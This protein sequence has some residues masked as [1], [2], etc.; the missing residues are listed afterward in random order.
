MNQYQ[1]NNQDLAPL[2]ATQTEVEM[3]DIDM[4]LMERFK[5]NND[6]LRYLRYK[7]VKEGLLERTG[8]KKYSI[9]KNR[10][11][12]IPDLTPKEKKIFKTL[13]ANKPYL[14][15]CVWRTSILNE[16]TRHQVGRFMIMVE[17]ER[18]GVEAVFDLLRDKYPNV[19]LNPTDKEIDFYISALY[20][21]IVVI[22]LVSE[23]P[24]Q[25]IDGI[26]T[27][28][29]EKLLVDILTEDKLYQ[30]FQSER[31][32]IIFEVNSKYILN[33]NKLLRYANRRR[34]KDVI[35]NL[36]NNALI[37]NEAEK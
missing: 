5:I 28:T 21:A 15:I 17:V 3:A 4:F 14:N 23:A 25:V 7:L 24:T 35:A 34:R 19:F 22:P 20:E 8:Y 1:L 13:R 10:T 32:R 37:R 27:V 18:V 36:M 16:F 33:T 11:N 9:R 2:F 12:Y 30:T 29:T 6:K 31:S 26:E